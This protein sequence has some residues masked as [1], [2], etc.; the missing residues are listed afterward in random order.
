MSVARLG[1]VGAGTMGAGIAQLACLSGYETLLAD[2]GEVALRTGGARVQEELKRGAERGR[3]SADAATAAGERL[4]LVPDLEGLAECQ[5]VIEAVPEDLAL[6]HAVLGRVAGACAPGTV[7]ATNTSSLRVSAVAAGVENPERVVG[8]HF[9]NP[10]AA[11]RLLE[12]VPGVATDERT[13]AVASEAGRRMG[14]EVIVA[15]DG[16]GF[17]ANR[18]ARPFAGEALRLLAERC[19]TVEQIDRICRLEGGFR[20]G[21]LELV[22]L[23]GVDVNLEIARSF[24]EQSFGEARWRPS[25]LQAS[26]VAAGRLGRKSGAGFHDYPRGDAPEQPV[27][28]RASPVRAVAIDGDTPLAAELRALAA[29]AGIEVVDP[30]DGGAELRVDCSLD[31]PGPIG[32]ATAPPAGGPPTAAGARPAPNETPRVVLCARRTLAERDP[33]AC[34][35]HLM[36]PLADARLVELTRLPSTD[37]AAPAA[38]ERFFAS[39]GLAV[40]WVADRPGL[41]LG[42][43]V[44]QLVNEAAFALA[45]GVGA[46][47]DVDR[48]LTLGLN[49]PRGP[50]EWSRAAGLEHVVAVLD[51]LWD[52]YREER[53]RVAPLL[54]QAVAL[55][56][57]LER[58][59]A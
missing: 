53:Y 40:E 46:P 45:E 22:D 25:P 12:V 49:H 28:P 51:G 31:G 21:P 58:A 20:M 24:Y 35:F 18:C 5:L 13:L 29:A 6:K 44:C 14:R 37:P 52:L 17:L 4:Y 48:G 1:V 43:I 26:L 23:I 39:C 55:G 59:A 30:A 56:D 9:F 8:M 10:P 50:L 33:A 36:P 11:M 19:A 7:L 41:V 42:R 3:W 47:A 57:D 34:G 2:S 16:I 27:A 32:A 15:R 54:R 38:A